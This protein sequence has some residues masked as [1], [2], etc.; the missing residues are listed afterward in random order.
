M[1]NPDV[2]KATLEEKGQNLI[3]GLE[4]ILEDLERGKGQLSIKMTDL[5]AFEVGRNIAIT[6]G[7]V[8][9]QNRLFQL[10]QYS[11]STKEVYEI[12]LLFLPPWINKF[13]ILKYF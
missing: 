10:I 7:K 3:R 2:L 12:P 5:D 6:P 4:N 9:F 1:T 11:P 8:V 13:Y